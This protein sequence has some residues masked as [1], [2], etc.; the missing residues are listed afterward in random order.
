MKEKLKHKILCNTVSKKTVEANRNF[1][2]P[3][4]LEI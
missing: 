1:K 3:F 2:N 4:I